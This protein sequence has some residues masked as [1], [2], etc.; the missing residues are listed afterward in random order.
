MVDASL[1]LVY[2]FQSREGTFAT[3]PAWWEEQAKKK[4]VEAPES[5][6]SIKVMTIH[7]SKGLEFEHV[8]VPFDI[9]F[10]P[11]SSEQWLDF[12]AS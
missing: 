7:K 3:L 1:D 11:D 8:I 6:P 4:N 5:T 10:K 12:P 2:E 9:N